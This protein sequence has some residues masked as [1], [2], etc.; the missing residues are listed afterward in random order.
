M[1]NIYCDESCHLENDHQKVMTLGALKVN[2]T[3]RRIFNKDIIKIKQKFG[4][5]SKTEIKWTKVSPSR[6]DFY[7]AIIDYFFENPQ[8]SFRVIVA[9]KEGLSHERFNQDHDDW[10]YKMYYLLLNYLIEPSDTYNIYLDIKD[11]IGKYK[12]E[13]LK[14]ILRKKIGDPTG[15]IISNIQLV[16]SDEV[17]LL[18]VTDLLIGAIGYYHRNLATSTAKL[19]LVEYVKHKSKFNTGLNKL[20]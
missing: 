13:T 14:D 15:E 4:I 10:Y 19:E 9:Q 16:R 7:K 18:Q 8:L 11:T 2:H 17:H 20:R 6:L 12:K 5:S 1:F 3:Y